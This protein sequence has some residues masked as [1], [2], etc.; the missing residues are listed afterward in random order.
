MNAD[1]K[2]HAKTDDAQPVAGPHWTPP[3]APMEMPR[4]TLEVSHEARA[5]GWL[6]RLFAGS[7]RA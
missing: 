1:P 3:T 5:P 2:T 7:Q 4:Q 6:M